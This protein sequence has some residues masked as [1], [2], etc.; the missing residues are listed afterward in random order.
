MRRETLAYAKVTGPRRRDVYVHDPGSRVR[1]L[2]HGGGIEPA[3][4]PDGESLAFVRAGDVYLIGASGRRLRLLARDSSFRRSHPTDV[5]SRPSADRRR[6][7][8]A[9]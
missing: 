9:C 6:V 2:T 7:R 4:A 3:W 1:R 5:G 8:V